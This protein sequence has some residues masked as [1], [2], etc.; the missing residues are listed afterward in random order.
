MGKFIQ[1]IILIVMLGSAYLFVSPYR[2]V[3]KLITAIENEDAQAVDDYVDFDAVKAAFQEDFVTKLGLDPSASAFG[4][5]LATSLSG[6]FLNSIISPETMII[7]LKDPQ[8]RETMGLAGE[9]GDLFERGQWKDTSTFILNNESGRPT[10]LL[11]RSGLH[12][13]VKALRLK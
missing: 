3:Q 12:W 6:A 10:T 1:L 4:D 9:F 11:T 13:E 7:I 5:V 2:T 8:R